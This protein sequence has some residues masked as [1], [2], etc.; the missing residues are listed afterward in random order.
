MPRPPVCGWGID[1]LSDV[2]S[3]IAKVQRRP[4]CRRSAAGSDTCCRGRSRTRGWYAAAGWLLWYGGSTCRRRCTWS[5]TLH[6]LLDHTRHHHSKTGAH[7]HPHSATSCTLIFCHFLKAVGGLVH[8]EGSQVANRPHAASRI[9]RLLHLFRQRYRVDEEVD[10]L[11]AV[12][13]KVFA[14]LDSCSRRYLFQL[15][16]KV[17]H[18]DIHRG[19]QIGERSDDSVLQIRRNLFGGVF[20]LSPDQG[21]DQQRRVGNAIGE[22]SKTSQS[23]QA[24]IFVP[25]RDRL[26]RSPFLVDENLF[27][28]KIDLSSEGRLLKGQIQQLGQEWQVLG[29]QGVTSG[30]EFVHRL[31]IAIENGLLCLLND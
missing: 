2:R 5:T 11:Q 22:F 29:G 30:A 23:H 31:T 1:Q 14:D 24:K 7:S 9:D 12:L 19:E 10:Q 28:D 25:E 13:G 8:R 3:E 6:G 20:P 27:P 18:A 26:T 21:I 15:R 17:K 4:F 16:L